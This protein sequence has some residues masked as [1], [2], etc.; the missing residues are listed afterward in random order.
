MKKQITVLLSVFIFSALISTEIKA[1]GVPQIQA[2]TFEQAAKYYKFWDAKLW[3]LQRPL[4]FTFWTKEDIERVKKLP[5]LAARMEKDIKE[6]PK[7]F[8]LYPK[9]L[10]TYFQAQSICNKNYKEF[11]AFRMAGENENPPTDGDIYINFYK[12]YCYW[13]KLMNDN[14]KVIFDNAANAMLKAENARENE[15]AEKLKHMKSYSEALKILFPKSEKADYMLK[16]TSKSSDLANTSV[17]GAGYYKSKADILHRNFAY[18]SQSPWDADMLYKVK[19]FNFPEF[20]KKIIAD[21]AEHPDWFK[22]YPA[23]LP[24]SGMGC[25]TKQNVNQFTAFGLAGADEKPSQNADIKK[26]VKFYQEYAYWK[27][28]MKNNGETMVRNLRSA[29]TKVGER[30]IDYRY[31][32]AVFALNY[33]KTLHQVCPDNERINELVTDAQGAYTSTVNEIRSVFSGKFHENNLQQIVVFKNKPVWGKENKAD[34]VTEVK[35]G[36]P[37]WLT[38]FFTAVNSM[39][40]PSLMFMDNS[41]DY[42]HGPKAWVDKTDKQATIPMFNQLELKSKYKSKAYFTF[43]LFPDI[44]TLNYKSHVQYFPHLNFIKWLTYQPSE[45]LDLRVKYGKKKKMAGGIIKIDL[46]G[47]N[48]AKLKEYLKKLEAKRLASVTYPDMCGTTNATASIS[49]FSDLSKYG[50][51]LRI[52]LKKAG[53]IMKP[54]PNDDQVDWNTAKGF[55]AV[56]QTDG[57]VVILALDF[58]KRPGAGKWQWW[59]LGSF[60]GLYPG[61]DYGYSDFNAVKK[62][63]GG[64][65]ILKQNI[66]K[67][68]TWYIR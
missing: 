28:V 59:S 13:Q 50:K 62:I 14:E 10:K 31:E 22:I 18:L 58:R 8:M 35:V 54:W 65:E 47:D 53:D 48:K 38:G 21:K 42:A 26:I 12:R 52:T 41:K 36:E 24:G 45:M 33:A 9:Q 67:S 32:E 6:H 11:A 2:L 56:E 43:N 15:Q 34:I 4:V 37:A 20:Y 7:Y 46:S 40:L 23:T 16:R 57:K 29:I 25:M 55:M 68:S 49:N 5:A 51:V 66:N 3:G 27:Q 30:H 60:P 19:Q 61:T 39:G 64:Y 17:G 44:N 1:Q 63:S